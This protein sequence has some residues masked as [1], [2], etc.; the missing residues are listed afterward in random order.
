MD[1]IVKEFLVESNEGLDQLERDLVAQEKDPEEKNLLGS[2]FRAIHTVKGTSGV[3]G[4]P[5]IE[6]VAHAGESLLSRMRDGKLRLDPEITSGLL[7]MGDGLRELLSHIEATGVEGNREV[8]AV[9]ERLGTLLEKESLPPVVKAAVVEAPPAKMKKKR[10]RTASMA[11]EMAP[12]EPND[13]PVVVEETVP[14][15]ACNGTQKARRQRDWRFRRTIYGS[16]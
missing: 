12:P 10:V 8:Q 2:I 9:V 1:E 6:S 14:P 5:K 11:Q 15:A 3:L 16:M 13:E 7:A 4:F